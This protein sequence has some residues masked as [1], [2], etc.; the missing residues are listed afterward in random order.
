LMMVS[1]GFYRAASKVLKEQDDKSRS[2]D[3]EMLGNLHYVKDLG[4]RC[5]ESL[6][7]G[8][9]ARFGLL[10]HEHW[11]HKKKRS[12]SMSN[13]DIDKWYQLALDNGAIGGK[14]IGAGGGGFLLFYTEEKTKLKKALQQANLKEVPIKFD[15]EGTKIL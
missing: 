5:L 12:A 7:S 1:T 13:P 9:L 8:N 6:E 10:M 2:M 14:L 3:S 4:Y 15:Y 11:M